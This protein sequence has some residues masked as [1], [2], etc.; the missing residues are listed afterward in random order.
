MIAA[1]SIPK[2]LAERFNAVGQQGPIVLNGVKRTDLPSFLTTTCCPKLETIKGVEVGV[3]DGRFSVHLCKS[4]P[5]LELLC[6]D[7]WIRY[8]DNPRGG[9]QAQHTGNY[10]HATAALAPYKA[11]LIRAMSL[12]AVRDVPLRSLDF[13]YLDGHHSFD[14]IMRDLIEWSFRVKPGGIVAGHDYY[15]FQWAGVVEAVNAYTRAHQIREWFITD[16]REPSFVWQNPANLGA[17][18]VRKA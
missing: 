4:L 8:P 12:D 7:P 5:K 1:P 10:E 2:T 13:C 18:D 16:E 17:E 3:A 15:A 11:T 9:G 6:V 14:W